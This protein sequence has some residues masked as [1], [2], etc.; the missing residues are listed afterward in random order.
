MWEPQPLT[1]LRASKA[2]RGENFTFFTR[3]VRPE[4]F[5]TGVREASNRDVQRIAENEKLNP[6][7]ESAPFGAENRGLGIVEGSTPS[8]AEK[9][10]SRRV[11]AGNVGVPATLDSFIPTAGTTENSTPGLAETLSGSLSNELT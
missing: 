4:G 5:Q 10:A 9:E 6:V 1:T 11:R 8:E 7:E 3:G 2:C